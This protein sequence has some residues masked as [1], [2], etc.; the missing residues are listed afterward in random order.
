MIRRP[1]IA[2]AAAALAAAVLAAPAAAHIQVRP[3]AVAPG[4]PVLF[5][6]L[7]PGER[8]AHTVKVSLQIPEDVLPFSWE[9][10]PGW[11]RTT[12]LKPDGSI[13]VVTWTGKLEEDGFA[14]FAFLAST[15]E[16]EGE[17]VWK[18]LQYYDDDHESA[19][20]GAPA[21]ENPAPVTRVSN[22][23]P[24]ENAGGESGEAQTPAAATATASPQPAATAAAS[25]PADTGG[26]S[27]IAL[28]VAIAALALALAA[29]L[30]ALRSRRPAATTS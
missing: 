27:P 5:Q 20:I 24:R 17:I 12:K 7:V 18:A 25:T 29:L 6:V 2:F 23:V 13:D 3:T 1:L 14:R 21:S 30:L 9:A 10:S 15:P 4:D 22:S 26:D 16:E 28:L 8:D 19:W 11:T